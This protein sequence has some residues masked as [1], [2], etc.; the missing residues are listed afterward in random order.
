MLRNIISHKYEVFD[1]LLFHFSNQKLGHRRLFLF[2]CND[3]PHEGNLMLQ[4]QARKRA[5]DLFDV[6]IEIHLMHIQS[7]G[8]DFDISKFYQVGRLFCYSLDLRVVMD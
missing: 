7:P 5:S 3:N 6:G 8:T 2:T 4:T 1:F